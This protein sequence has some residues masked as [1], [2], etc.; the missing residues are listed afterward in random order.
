MM[1]GGK[2]LQPRNRGERQREAV[3][4]AAAEQQPTLTAA[5]V[6]HRGFFLRRRQQLVNLG[7]DVGHLRQTQHVEDQ[8]HLAVAHDGGAG[9]TA[10]CP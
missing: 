5:I 8:R 7:H 2:F 10:R 4:I 3:F 1:S 6:L 9:K